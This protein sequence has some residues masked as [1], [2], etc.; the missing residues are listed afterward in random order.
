M[1]LQAVAPSMATPVPVLPAA[2]TL[3]ETEQE[4]EPPLD[5][6]PIPLDWKRSINQAARSSEMARP[7]PHHLRPNPT[8]LARQDGKDCVNFCITNATLVRR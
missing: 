2:L 8:L 4:E 1:A 5:W 6:L 3:P 7:S